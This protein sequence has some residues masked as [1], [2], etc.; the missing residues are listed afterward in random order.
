MG[1]VDEFDPS[2]MA[3]RPSYITDWIIPQA[4]RFVPL[5]ELFCSIYVLNNFLPD[6]ISR[7]DT[8]V[9]NNISSLKIFQWG[10]TIQWRFVSVSFST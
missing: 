5:H 1:L 3:R 4:G 10:T 2:G 7:R 6:C 9:M 8:I